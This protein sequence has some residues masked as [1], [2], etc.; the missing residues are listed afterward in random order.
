MNRRDF[1]RQLALIAAGAAA[2]PSQIEAFTNLY[3]VNSR[4]LSGVDMISINNITICGLAGHSLPTHIDL[5][6]GDTLVL[7]MGINLFGGMMIWYAHPGNCI[8]ANKGDVRVRI[9]DTSGHD[10]DPYCARGNVVFTDS[11]MLVSSFQI[12]GSG[13][14][15][16]ETPFKAT[17]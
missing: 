11:E 12:D 7:P 14:V 2:L 15:P 17:R 10:V 1:C 9:R 13:I 6:R 4:G 3:E 16:P 5:M 8:I